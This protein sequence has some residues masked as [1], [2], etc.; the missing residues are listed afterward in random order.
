MTEQEDIR[1]IKVPSYYIM[2]SQGVLEYCDVY[3]VR[4]AVSLYEQNKNKEIAGV[5]LERNS[6]QRKLDLAES[7][8]NSLEASQTRWV[9]CSERLPEKAGYYFTS[10]RWVRWFQPD[11]QEWEGVRAWLEN[12]PEFVP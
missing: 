6:L 10:A 4:A 12:V 9:K 2:L 1:E 5:L 8:I 3:D 11:Y 7:K